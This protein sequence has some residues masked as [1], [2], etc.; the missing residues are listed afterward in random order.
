[1]PPAWDREADIEIPQRVLGAWTP[2]GGVRELRR[3]LTP[4]ERET[5]A[6]RAQALADALHPY[7]VSERTQVEIA[8]GGMLAGFRSMRQIGADGE[9]VVIVMCNVLRDFP[10]WAIAQGCIAI[11]QGR[12]VDEE[13]KPLDRRWP[14]NDAQVYAVVAEIV[15]VH[16]KNLAQAQGLL[17]ATV[18]APEPVRPSGEEIEAALGRPVAPKVLQS[19]FVA[20]PERLPGDGKHF[21][22]IKADLEARR[23]RRMAPDEGEQGASAA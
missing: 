19:T 6:A 20:P 14:P 11:A 23:A 18:E 5:V 15:R 1:M 8:I 3:A 9:A 17:V 4:A 13:G 2:A 16:R 7:T 21:E 12:A 10:P 22:R